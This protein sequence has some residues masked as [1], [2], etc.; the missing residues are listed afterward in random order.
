MDSPIQDGTLY[1]MK[2]QHFHQLLMRGQSQTF[3]SVWLKKLPDFL[4][5]L[6]GNMNDYKINVP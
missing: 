2:I 6:S 3:G 1:L 5:K 4:D